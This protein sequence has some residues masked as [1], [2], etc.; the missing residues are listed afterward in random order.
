M[1][2]FTVKQYQQQQQYLS[3]VRRTFNLKKSSISC[4]SV[5]MQRQLSRLANWPVRFHFLVLMADRPQL[6]KC[7]LL[8]TRRY[9][10][11]SGELS[12][13]AP[14]QVAVGHPH[15]NHQTACPSCLTSLKV[16]Y[17]HQCAPFPGKQL[18]SLPILI[19]WSVQKKILPS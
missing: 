13:R 4:H 10:S 1:F 7:S 15:L 18:F 12:E 19:D 2:C 8:A 17:H 9:F 16:D 3:T 11:A 14:A 6:N 5:A